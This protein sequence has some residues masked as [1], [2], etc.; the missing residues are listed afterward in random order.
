MT[1]ERWREVEEKLALQW[2]PEQIS[3]RLRLEGRA[4]VSHEW[5]YKRVWKDREAG[6]TLHRHLRHCGKK[7][8]SRA[9]GQAGRGCIPGRMDIAERPGIVEEKSRVGDWEGDTVVGAGHRGA[10][11][12]LVDRASRFTLLALLGGRTAGETGEAMRRRLG[13]YKEF[14]H[15][16]DN[17]KEFAARR[18]V[19]GA[20]VV[21]LRAAVP[22]ARPE[23][24]HE[25]IGS[26]VQ[27]DRFLQAGPRRTQ[28][29]REP[30]QQPAAQGAGLPDSRGSFQ[31]GVDRGDRPLSSVT[32]PTRGAIGVRAHSR[33][34]PNN[35]AAPPRRASAWGRFFAA[36]GAFAFGRATPSLRRTPPPPR[37]LDSPAKQTGLTIEIVGR[38]CCTSELIAGGFTILGLHPLA[39]RCFSRV[40]P[41]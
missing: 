34:L 8:N 31:T 15:T 24:A 23:R 39:E 28:A 19:A 30:A 1:P 25:R 22:G 40:M 4:T 13:P 16:T 26:P 17:G 14:V 37:R 21:L 33:R 5:I 38:L 41:S 9:R 11:L 27:G 3:G 10:V 2:S 29:R 7:P 35:C 20:R 18:E 6:G 36:A 12:S 32:G